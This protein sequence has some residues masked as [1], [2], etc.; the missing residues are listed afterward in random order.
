MLIFCSSV[1]LVPA[2]NTQCVVGGGLFVI[3][4]VQDFLLTGKFTVKLKN[5]LSDFREWFYSVVHACETLLSVYI[6]VN[7][8]LFMLNQQ[9]TLHRL[10]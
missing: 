2:F 8:S 6:D 10:P 1:I 3:M 7:V 5:L 4:N 9:G